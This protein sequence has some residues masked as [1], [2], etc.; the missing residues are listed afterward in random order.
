MAYSRF[1]GTWGNLDF[2][3]KKFYKINYWNEKLIKLGKLLSIAYYT[4]MNKQTNHKNR[5]SCS[6]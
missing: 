5:L 2:Y 3:K 1:F 4:F 6:F